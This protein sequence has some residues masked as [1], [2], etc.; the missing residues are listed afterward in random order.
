VSLESNKQPLALVLEALD[1]K[2]GPDV[3]VKVSVPTGWLSARA[4]IRVVL[5]RLAA[6]V[7]CD[8]GGCERCSGQGALP[9][10]GIED[11]PADVQVHL[12]PVNPGQALLLRLPDLGPEPTGE[13]RRGCVLLEV[14][15]QPVTSGNVTL[16]TMATVEWKPSWYPWAA[17]AAALVVLL[18]VAYLIA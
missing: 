1:P 17:L 18:F 3:R 7:V 13:G 14:S 8:G 15:A 9:L 2:R 4:S 5:P 12:N 10:R 11:L 6:C 16:V